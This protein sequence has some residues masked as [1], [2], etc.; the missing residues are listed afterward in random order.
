MLSWVFNSLWAMAFTLLFH[1]FQLL[2]LIWR[3]CFAF[4]MKLMYGKNLQM[5]TLILIH[6]SYVSFWLYCFNKNNLKRLDKMA[7]IILIKGFPFPLLL[8]SLPFIM[9]HGSFY[10]ATLLSLQFEP[11]FYFTFKGRHRIEYIGLQF[12]LSKA[13][14]FFGNK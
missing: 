10:S 5:Y 12:L 14:T 1:Y 6:I 9:S 4:E 13:L 2:I 8:S 11:S 7:E 3:F